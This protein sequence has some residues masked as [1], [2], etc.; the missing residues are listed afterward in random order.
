M[1]ATL[2]IRESMPNSFFENLREGTYMVFWSL[3]KER[4][5]QLFKNPHSFPIILTFVFPVV[6]V[7]GITLSEKVFSIISSFVFLGVLVLGIILFVTSSLS[8]MKGLVV[9]AV[10]S[11]LMAMA[12]LFL[13]YSGAFSLLGIR[14]FN[15][16][17]VIDTATTL[18]II[19][20]SSV[21]IVGVFG[22]FKVPPL[23]IMQRKMLD[24]LERL[25]DKLL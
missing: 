24:I 23:I 16:V 21:L 11:I 13:K 25:R 17:S 9:I 20:M 2:S 3:S 10:I 5:K 4:I 7:L 8:I 1:K 22:V 15:P 12:V 14:S 18:A 19:G 6:L